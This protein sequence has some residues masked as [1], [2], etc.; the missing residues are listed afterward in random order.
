MKIDASTIYM[1]SERT[2]QKTSGVSQSISMKISRGKTKGTEANKEDGGKQLGKSDQL[3]QQIRTL[4][5]EIK[6]I[7]NSSPFE[8]DFWDDPAIDGLR[9]LLELFGMTKRSQ[10]EAGSPK[11]LPN[12]IS[13][14]TGG[15]LPGLD[16]R[17]DPSGPGT[18]WTSE[19]KTSSFI[20]ESEVTSFSANG[21]VRTS[22]GRELSFNME[23]EMSRSFME[24]SEVYSKQTMSIM[25][26]PLI[27][28]LDSATASVTDQKFLFDLDADGDLENI[29]FAGQGSGFLALDKNGDGKI[30]DGNELFGTKSGNGFADL[31]AYDKDKNGWIDETDE[32]FSKLKIWTKDKDGNDRL[33]SLAEAGVGAIYL[34]NITTEFSL[35]D[36]SNNQN[37]QVRKTGV[38][39]REDGKAGTIQ[40]V[41]LAL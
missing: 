36:E 14:M 10:T 3:R 12:I 19:I 27:I 8:F 6:P 26:D 39:L 28:N 18:L 5:D 7:Q 4:E 40:H 30:N 13:M 15:S 31:A 1:G 2:Y 34:G 25:T 20:A 32:V 22:D 37:A 41:D 24:Y 17:S 23:L 11:K 33:L 9:K 35:K 29:S 21:I 16:L 38:Y